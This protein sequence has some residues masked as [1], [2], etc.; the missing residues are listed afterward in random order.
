MTYIY[1]S[2]ICLFPTSLGSL[3]IAWYPVSWVLLHVFHP[4][5]Q[6]FQV[7]GYSWSLLLSFGR[8]LKCPFSLLFISCVLGRALGIF[9]FPDQVG[10]WWVGSYLK[11]WTSAHN[12]HPLSLMQ[13]VKI[14][15]VFLG[16]GCCED[17][18]TCLP[19]LWK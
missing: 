6:W 1:I 13:A 5:F 7:G 17:A 10:W 11:C 12:S 19:V 14:D 8:T 16:R 9:F 18:K 4:V 3:S 15:N 2:R